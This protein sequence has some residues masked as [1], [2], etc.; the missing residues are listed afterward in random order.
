MRGHHGF[1]T[2]SGAR[3]EAWGL[4]KG[5]GGAKCWRQGCGVREGEEV[6]VRES[7]LQ[8]EQTQHHS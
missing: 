7:D 3:G 2:H 5:T 6:V 4:G 8:V 1:P